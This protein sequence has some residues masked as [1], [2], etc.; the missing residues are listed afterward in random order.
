MDMEET[1]IIKIIAQVHVDHAHQKRPF[2]QQSETTLPKPA[3]AVILVRL[4]A[5][6]LLE[7]MGFFAAD[8]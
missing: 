7:V 5:A 6:N 4:G 8:Q 1:Q 2:I 3:R